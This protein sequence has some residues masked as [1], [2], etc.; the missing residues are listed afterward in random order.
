LKPSRLLPE[1]QPRA[2]RASWVAFA[3][4]SLFSTPRTLVEFPEEVNM[5][6]FL[7]TS[8]EHLESLAKMSRAMNAQ[9]A[10][11]ISASAMAEVQSALNDYWVELD[12]SDLSEASKGIY[13][14]NAD[15][16]VRWMRNDFTPGSR[17]GTPWKSTRAK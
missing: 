2:A 10:T 11:R 7:H 8:R 3:E 4:F 17:N 12:A 13:M 16:F 9:R 1:H 15:N 14:A 5:G 6:D